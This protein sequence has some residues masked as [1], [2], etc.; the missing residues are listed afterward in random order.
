MTGG[1]RIAMATHSKEISEGR[2]IRLALSVRLLK[3][4]HADP[5][6]IWGPYQHVFVV[7]CWVVGATRL[8]LLRFGQRTMSMTSAHAL[9]AVR[10]VNAY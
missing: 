10:G 8:Q 2:G 5:C 9:T 6:F 7:A 1:C 4:Q 3:G